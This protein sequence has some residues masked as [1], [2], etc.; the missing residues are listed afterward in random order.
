MA[1]ELRFAFTCGNTK[2]RA[3]VPR[4]R[5]PKGSESSENR[6]HPLG[7]PYSQYEFDTKGPIP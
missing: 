2:G 5:S 1:S 6:F 3:N 7:P 4:S